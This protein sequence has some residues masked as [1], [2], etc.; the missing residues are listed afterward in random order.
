MEDDR[1]RRN[2]ASVS[3]P[4]AFPC[5]G[6]L[7]RRGGE[8]AALAV[9]WGVWDACGWKAASVGF[10]WPLRCMA[11]AVCGSVACQFPGAGWSLVGTGPMERCGSVQ[12]TLEAASAFS[13]ETAT[14][15]SSCA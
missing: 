1:S 6:A 10:S 12:K 3:S 7:E 14:H 4:A 2:T 8:L 15:H 5:S 11:A 13:E 9:A